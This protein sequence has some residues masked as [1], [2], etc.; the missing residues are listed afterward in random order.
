[1]PL[2]GGGGAGNTAGGNPSGTGT[3]LNYVG[4][5]A[6]AYS[7]EIDNNGSSTSTALNF[8]TGGEYIVGQ[9]HFIY[10]TESGT[11]DAAYTLKL[12]SESVYALTLNGNI[13]DSNR[14][15]VE[16]LIPPFSHVEV[17]VQRISGSGTI[18]LGA[19]FTGRVY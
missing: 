18:A 15:D 2:V 19:T 8:T 3:S 4:D 11:A 6:Y 7:G 5:H 17:L 10:F 9:M 12:N 13:N 1:M 14:P 16:I